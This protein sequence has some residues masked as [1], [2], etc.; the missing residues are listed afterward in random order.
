MRAAATTAADADRALSFALKLK[1]YCYLVNTFIFCLV[2]LHGSQAYETPTPTDSYPDN[3]HVVRKN[4]RQK[5]A[6]IFDG[7]VRKHAAKE[8]NPKKLRP[9]FCRI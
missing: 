3:A 1:F 7:A 2:Q 5:N 8:G 6:K 4:L 9:T